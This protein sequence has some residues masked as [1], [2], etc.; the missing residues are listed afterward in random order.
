VEQLNDL[1]SLAKLTSLSISTCRKLIKKGLPHY[2]I[3]RKILVN[4]DECWEWMQR[5]KNS[6]PKSN[7]DLDQ[8]IEKTLDE[9][10]ISSS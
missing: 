7:L 4:E 5:F 6:Q 8:L 9:I 3:N 10:E 1:K 2:L